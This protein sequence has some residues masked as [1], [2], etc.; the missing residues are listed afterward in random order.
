MTEWNDNDWEDTQESQP[1][2]NHAPKKS[3]KWLVAGLI[4][5][6]IIGGSGIYLANRPKPQETVEPGLAVT[7]QNVYNKNYKMFETIKEQVVEYENYYIAYILG[8]ERYISS[9]EP[10]GEFKYLGDLISKYED[11]ERYKEMSLDNDEIRNYFLSQ[12]VTTAYYFNERDTTVI[13]RLLILDEDG[14]KGSG[15][16]LTYNR[17]GELVKYKEISQ[18]LRP[19]ET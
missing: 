14:H 4:A 5:A 7:P 6:T 2:D 8:F 1:L 18:G 3:K 12:Y 10:L 16:L 11:T 13:C 15:Y 17:K 9:P 19:F